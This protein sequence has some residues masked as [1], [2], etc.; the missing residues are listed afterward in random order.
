M[1]SLPSLPALE[2]LRSI[3]LLLAVASLGTVHGQFWDTVYRVLNGDTTQGPDFDTAYVASYRNDLVLSPVMFYQQNTLSLQRRDGGDLTFSTNTPVQYGLALD[4]KWLGVEYTASIP[5]M[6]TM[7]TTLGTTESRGLGFGYTGRSWW[8]R[9]FIRSSK[10]YYAQDPVL[11]VSDWEEGDPYPVRSDL[12]NVT[13]GASLNYGFNHRRYSQTA[14]LWQMERQKRSAGTF[15]AGATFWYSRTRSGSR[16]LPP[17]E[18]GEYYTPVSVAEVQ[19]W[20]VSLTAGYA[21]TFAFWKRGFLNIMLI[22]GIGAQEQEVRGDDGSSLNSGW[23][24]GG[25]GEVRIGTGYVAD[26]WYIGFTTFSFVSSG[27]VL[28]DVRMGTGYGNLRLAAGWRI[29][30]AGPFIPALGL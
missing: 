24:V 21:H 29:K 25:T 13:Y 26:K 10:G 14:A 22:P 4:Y 2:I 16:L 7:D 28:E 19:R 8:F 3:L 17:N 5:G 18:E 1:P 20:T 27:E 30:G 6:S 15:T 12:E 11:L 23:S 9:N